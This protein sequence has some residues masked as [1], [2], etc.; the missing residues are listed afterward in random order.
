MIAVTLASL[1]GAGAARAQTLDEGVLQELN[2]ARL[3]PQEYARLLQNQP[4]SSWDRARSAHGDSD[5]EATAQAIAFLMRQPPLPALRADGQ[6]AAAAQEHVR[7]QGPTGAIGHEG[8]AGERFDDRLRRHGV[9]AG[10]LAENIAYGPATPSDVIRELII[11]SGVPD[12][13]HRRN[14]FY[15]SFD[16]AGVSCGPHRGYAVMCVIDFASEAGEPRRTDLASNTRAT[17]R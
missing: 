10:T 11:D 17:G 9:Q 7:A 3:H 12:R 5:P 4:A 6:L 14:I 13:G 16:A 15:Q 2:F 8:Q 1:A